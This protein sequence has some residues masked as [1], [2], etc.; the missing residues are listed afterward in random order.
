MLGLVSFLVLDFFVF[1]VAMYE[2]KSL[3]SLSRPFWSARVIV[4][5][6]LPIFLIQG[7]WYPNMLAL[8]KL[9]TLNAFPTERCTSLQRS[10]DWIVTNS[11]DVPLLTVTSMSGTWSLESD[12][13][14]L[15]EAATA[16]R[17]G[18][19]VEVRSWSVRAFHVSISGSSTS[20]DVSQAHQ[21]ISGI[22]TE[23]GRSRRIEAIAVINLCEWICLFPVLWI[24]P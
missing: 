7:D 17:R 1:S 8:S 9:I 18:F 19:G 11:D 15:S 4:W 21:K 14:S 20:Q 13:S 10:L 23:L 6:L 3:L 16:D 5:T 2:I 22:H 12:S 24:L